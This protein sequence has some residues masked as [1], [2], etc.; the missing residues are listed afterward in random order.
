LDKKPVLRTLQQDF[1]LLL[2]LNAGKE[3][4]IT[5]QREDE[6][7]YAFPSGKVTDYI[8]TNFDCSSLL[9]V[10]QGTKRKKKTEAHLF[11]SNQP[12]PDSMKVR[13]FNF[14]MTLSLKKLAR[15]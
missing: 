10:E 2:M 3:D 8:V 1:E 15:E 6:V 12:A 11:Y 4:P 5:Y 13:H 9:R 7:Y 14:N